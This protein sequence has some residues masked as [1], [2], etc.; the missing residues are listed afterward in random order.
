M[1]SPSALDSHAPSNTRKIVSW[2][3]WDWGTQP[4]ATVITTFV[5]AVYLTSPN[6]G[7]EN[8]TSLALSISVAVSGLFIALLAPVLGQSSDRSG[9]QVSNLRLLT[10]A[11]A[12]VSALMFFVKPE[13][14]YLWLGLVLLGVGSIVAEIANVNYYALLDV[15]ATDKNVGRISG[16]GWGLG[17][18]GG[19]VVLLLLF[20]GFIA[21]DVG[22]FGVTNAEGLDI[23]VSMLVCALWTLVFTIP[24]FISLKDAPRPVGQQRTRW[25]VDVA[26]HHRHSLAV[27]AGAVV[28]LVLGA[29]HLLGWDAGL[30]QRAWLMAA[31]FAALALSLVVFEAM[32]GPVAPQKPAVFRQPLGYVLALAFLAFIWLA[33]GN[34]RLG[35]WLL[36]ASIV[37]S[38]LW[39]AL[40]ES[41]RRPD[42]LLNR[43]AS[44]YMELG[45]SIKRTW[46]RSPHTVYF[47]LS[48]A[49]FRDGLAGVFAFGG[50][51]AAGSF[52][53]TPS[54]VIIF[55]AAANVVAGVATMGFGLI[56]DWLGP[57]KVIMISLVSLVLLCTGVF[58]LHDHGKIV[59]WTLGLALTVF[60]GPAQS[61]SRSFL[62]RIIPEGQAGEMFG[63]YATTGRVVAFFSP[64]AF[65]LAVALGAWVTGSAQTQYWGILGIVV[66]LAAGALVL[67][68]VKEPHEIVAGA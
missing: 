44:S 48:S 9:R 12:G 52:N 2:A 37:C 3:F 14:H 58:V 60:V 57:K 15:V 34:D 29:A 4:F 31:A 7:S 25:I 21:P 56:D 8:Q 42:A 55:G 26:Q 16:F 13:P 33:W 18:L 11:L 40:R 53:F 61:A 20:F 36:L 54:E 38:L 17:Y 32:G 5:F 30:A 10:W 63:L 67:L 19:I 43:A 51:L 50:V 49:L 59:F 65:G 28:A 68:P 27:I 39:A 22:L 1:S 6:F 62:A 41:A 47:L 46:R 45:R 24:L 35:L 23:R 64:T 66:V